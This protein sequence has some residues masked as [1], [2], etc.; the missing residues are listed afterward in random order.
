MRRYLKCEALPEHPLTLEYGRIYDTGPI[1]YDFVDHWVFND[2]EALKNGA[3]DP[4][5]QG[6]MRRAWDST[7]DSREPTAA[8]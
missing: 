4:E 5:V 1:R 2:I 6:L 8:L 3:A 7:R